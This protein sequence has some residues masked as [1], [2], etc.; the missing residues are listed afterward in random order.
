MIRLFISFFCF[1]LLGACVRNDQE[2][3]VIPQKPNI[4]L[5]VVDDWGWKDA[6]FLGSQYYETPNLDA[7]AKEGLRFTNAYATAANCAPSRACM[8]SGKN[9]PHHGVYTVSPSTRGDARTRKLIPVKNIDSL[10]N[11]VYTLPRMMKNAGYVTASF[12]KWHVGKDPTLQGIDYNIG[13]SHRGNPGKNGYFSPYKIDHITDGP[14]GEYL[15]DRL[16]SEAI[17]FIERFQDSTFFL[18]LPFYTVHTPILGKEEWIKKY[19][20]KPAFEGHQDPVYGAMVSSMD[21]NIGRIFTKLKQ[22][23]LYDDSLV[24]LT[25]DN[26]GHMN[27]TDQQP[28]RAGKGSYYEGGIRVPLVMKWTG[29]IQQNAINTTRVTNLDFY[30]TLQN[31]VQPDKKATELD[32][33]D[34][35]PLFDNV[36]LADRALYFHF[37]IYL[38]SNQVIKGLRDPLFRT[39]PG[40]VIIDGRWK[41]H[42]YFEDNGLELYDLEKDPSEKENLEAIHAGI[43]DSLYQKLESWRN[44]TAAA[45]ASEP[46]PEYDPEFEQFS[47][48]RVRNASSSKK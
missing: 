2:N 47:S 15:T 22:L 30:P 32:G 48:Q 35:A 18:Y 40:S 46:N 1:L 3:G 6:H 45:M 26:G 39:R 29:H 44:Q 41:L 19:E 17:K 20:G 31:I 37:P 27:V 38:Q 23:D 21:E 12:G 4:I 11:E 24:I 13:G 7:F 8:L 33:L 9:T 5:I 25:S 14:D 43:R 36:P 16:A 34:L 28:L 42:H 10:D